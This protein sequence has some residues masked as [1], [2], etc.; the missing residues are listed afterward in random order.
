LRTL[1]ILANY[2]LGQ[3]GTYIVQTYSSDQPKPGSFALELANQ[4]AGLVQLVGQ[5][6][7]PLVA[8]TQCPNLAKA[9]TYQFISIPAPLISPSSAPQPYSWDPTTETAYGSVDISSSGSTVTFQNISQHTLPSVGV[10]GRPAQPAASS[11]TGACGPTF[12]GQTTSVPGQ[13]VVDAPGKPQSRVPPQATIGIGTTAGLLVED[14]GVTLNGTLPNS[15]PALSYENVLGAGTG[16]VG[17]PKPSS[18]VDVSSLIGAQY[19]GFLYGAGVY[20][21]GLL[22]T[23]WSSHLTSFGVGSASANCVWAQVK[24]GTTLCG[25]DF[26]SDDPSNPSNGRSNVA[27]DLGPQSDN[28]LFTQAMVWIDISYLGNTTGTQYHFPAVAIAGQIG[29]KYA[30][31]ALGVDSTQPWA[32]YLMQSN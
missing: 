25:G 5:P 26:L 20:N 14:N 31:F 13:L 28:G 32:I 12:F 11:A 22:Y 27:I 2:Y 19:L 10:A 7:A 8:A 6:A 21:N 1:G 15:S 30:I 3:G 23:G 4:V 17:L 9:Q 16:A 29:G 18:P 24:A